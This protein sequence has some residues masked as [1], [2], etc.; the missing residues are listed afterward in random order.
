MLKIIEV[1]VLM[2]AGLCF[3]VWQFRDLR[4]SREITRK[5]RE[6]EQNSSMN[7]AAPPPDSLE[8]KGSD[9]G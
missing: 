8:K 9:G 2:G 6:A 4:R 3:V 7:T 1:V 5:Q